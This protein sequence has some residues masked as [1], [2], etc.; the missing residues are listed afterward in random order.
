MARARLTDRMVRQV[1][2]PCVLIDGGGLRLKVTA[3]PKTK[4]L[5]KSWILRVTVKGG[6]I[7]ELGLGSA[8]DFSLQEVR[9]RAT[10]A[11]KL[12]RDGIDPVAHREA[13]RAQRALEAARALTFVQCAEAYIEAHRAGWR[14]A[15]H[16][17]QW[18][19]TLETYAY[20]VFGDLP[21]KTIDVTLVLKVLEPIW[22]T[23]S[24]WRKRS[25]QI[26]TRPPTKIVYRPMSASDMS[27]VAAFPL[28]Q[29]G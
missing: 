13:E 27:G 12:A 5:R 22:K 4:Q 3:N 26:T 15:K 7:R 28:F 16:A 23:S 1:R 18:S 25:S 6:P 2:V 17:A 8:D 19:A 20:P 9:D 11:R 24:L 21:V 10:I 29:T 14:N